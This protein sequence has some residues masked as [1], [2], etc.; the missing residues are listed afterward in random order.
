[1]IY[2]FHRFQKNQ[3]VFRKSKLYIHETN[4]NL[5]R[6]L[7]VQKRSKGYWLAHLVITMA[8]C[9]IKSN[10]FNFK[11]STNMIWKSYRLSICL[12]WDLFYCS[13]IAHTQHSFISEYFLI[14]ICL[15]SFNSHLVVTCF[16]EWI[17]LTRL[18]LS[19][20]CGAKCL[21]WVYRHP[22]QLFVLEVPTRVPPQLKP[23]WFKIW[24]VP[25]C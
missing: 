13:N 17:S 12:G 25:L 24:T 10:I 2:I 8:C 23:N 11:V 3:S 20:S 1:M 16:T 6:K 4:Q 19:A 7:C 18:N 15:Y 9:F 22:P 14:I 21:N 5:V